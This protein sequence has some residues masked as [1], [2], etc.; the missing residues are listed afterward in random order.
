MNINKLFFKY[1]VYYPVV[2]V[3]TKGFFKI[4][5]EM[6]KSQYLIP[7]SLSDLQMKKFSILFN[8]IR[9][10][11]PI[12][13]ELFKN[14]NINDIRSVDDLSKLPF[15]DKELVKTRYNDFL[16]KQ[17]PLFCTKK[18]TGGSTGQAVSILKSRKAMAYELAAT[19]RGYSWANIDI[20]DKQARFWGVPFTGKKTIMPRLIDFI[21]NR[22]RLSA[23]SFNNESLKFYHR[24]LL[25]FKPVYFYGYLSMME[26]YAKYYDTNNI[27]K[28]KNLKAII[29]T[30]EVL[31]NTKRDFLKKTFKTNVFNEYGCGEIGSIAHECE[32][33]N[34][35][36]SAE[37]MIIEIVN[38]NKNCDKGEVGEIVVTELNNDVFPLVR[39]KIG[40]FASF[41]NRTC[42]CG[43]TLPIIDKIKGRAYD[44]VTTKDGKKFHGEFFMYIFE[45][46]ERMKYGVNKF[47]VE[48][49]SL[50]EIVIK[51]VPTSSYK[52]KETET[53]IKKY[54]NSHLGKQI[55]LT[56]ETVDDISREKSGKMRLI[57]GMNK[58]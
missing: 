47:Q 36:I 17:I 31:H 25:S 2:M 43:R 45:E 33:G 41:A 52:A 37:N 21:C 28:L 15:V 26:E 16:T 57:I 54:V 13:T 35:H 19:W 58:R 42:P 51:I 11:N 32:Y 39:Y 38:G 27:S 30:S 4:L 6:N 40:D 14:I 22:I 1:C 44:I 53:M 5:R 9:I 55:S 20:G 10:R 23:F 49:K 29:S 56:F 48:Q 3:R 50:N 12:Y 7:K 34:M 24:K 46:V 8:K 18:T